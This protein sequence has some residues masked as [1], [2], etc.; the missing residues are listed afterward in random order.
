MCNVWNIISYREILK[1]IQITTD[2]RTVLF[3]ALHVDQLINKDSDSI[4]MHGRTVGKKIL[5]VYK[6]VGS[7]RIIFL[8]CFVVYLF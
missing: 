5:N 2:N 1:P 7:V 4:K 3:I 6:T 8:I